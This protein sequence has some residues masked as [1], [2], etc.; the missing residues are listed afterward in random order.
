M[1]V[2]TVADKYGALDGCRVYH[3]LISRFDSDT[4]AT[5]LSAFMGA[6]NPPVINYVNGLS[7][8]IHQWEA[9]VEDLENRH[10]EMINEKLRLVIFITM[11]PKEFRELVIQQGC[12]QKGNLIK[13]YE[14]FR[15]FVLNVA[16][17]KIETLKLVPQQIDQ[18]EPT[19]PDEN[20]IEQ[21]S[22]YYSSYPGYYYGIDAIKD[23]G[24]GRENRTCDNCGNAGHIARDCPHPKRGAKGTPGKGNAFPTLP[25]KGA[26]LAKG[27]GKG[28]PP[29]FPFTGAKGSGKE[30]FNGQC[31]QCGRA[32]T[33]GQTA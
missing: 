6:V 20:L 25:F 16:T 3:M 15:D 32:G 33:D 7:K 27:S 22:G 9:K 5:L 31:F 4:A 29:S 21:P 13:G 28:F 1:V 26:P 24:R 12:L 8:M 14:F 2:K 23:G 19:S 17:Q 30:P 11:L 18:V 10:N